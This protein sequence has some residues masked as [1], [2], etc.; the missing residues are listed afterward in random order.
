[1]P[2]QHRSR[3]I[4]LWHEDAECFG[5][6]L[7]KKRYLVSVK[8]EGVSPWLLNQVCRN[9]VRGIAAGVPGRKGVLMEPIGQDDARDAGNADVAASRE[10]SSYQV[11]AAG[12]ARPVSSRINAFLEHH[13]GQT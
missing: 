13:R 9:Q 11:K 2:S 3:S 4:R 12:A 10:A 1:M 6:V 5:S 7:G 8:Q